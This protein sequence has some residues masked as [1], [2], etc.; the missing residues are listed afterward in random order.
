MYFSHFNLKFLDVCS[1]FPCFHSCLLQSEHR[2]DI[3]LFFKLKSNEIANRCIYS[4]SNRHFFL[5]LPPL[6]EAVNGDLTC[7]VMRKDFFCCAYLH[8]GFLLLRWFHLLSSVPNNPLFFSPASTCW[9]EFAISTLFFHSTSATSFLSSFCLSFSLLSPSFLFYTL[10]LSPVLPKC[11]S[12]VY[13]L[14]MS[15][16]KD[17]YS[18][19]TAQLISQEAFFS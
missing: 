19:G 2:W 7:Q 16:I 4:N 6:H 3:L 9:P 5:F 10:A 15:I 8:F 18:Q 1:F 14:L 13:L 11:P 17:A 12:S